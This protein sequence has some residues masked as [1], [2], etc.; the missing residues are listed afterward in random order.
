MNEQIY[1]PHLYLF[2]Y[3]LRNG[4]GQNSSQLAEN[5]HRFWERLPDELKVDQSA[6]EE[7]GYTEDIVDLLKLHPD[8]KIKSKRSYKLAKE[9]FEYIY[10]PVR[11]NDTYGLLFASSLN[12]DSTT[13]PIDISI[14]G[15]MRN[16]LR[17]EEASKFSGSY[18]VGKTW[19]LAGYLPPDF[20]KLEEDS[21]KKEELAEKAEAIASEAYEK[22]TGNKW[23]YPQ[24]GKF[25][26][27]W[28]FEVWQPPHT[29]ENLDKNSHVLIIIYKNLNGLEESA[30]FYEHWLPLFC[31]RNKVLW[32]YS[33]SKSKN[34]KI[35]KS[36]KDSDQESFYPSLPKELE[37]LKEALRDNYPILQ[38][39]ANRISFLEIQLH[40]IEVNRKNYKK[41]LDNIIQKTKECGDN[42]T[43]LS[44][45]EKFLDVAEQKY[46][47]QIKNDCAVIE[48][49]LRVREKFIDTIKGIVEIEQATLDTKQATL[50]KNTANRDRDFQQTIQVW[51]VGLATAGVAATA[52]SP[53]MEKIIQPLAESLQ[54]KSKEKQTSLQQTSVQSSQ[55]N[56]V[57]NQCP[58]LPTSIWWVPGVSLLLTVLVSFGIGLF[59]ANL[60]KMRVRSS[61]GEN[62]AKAVAG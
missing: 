19:M 25:L 17:T 56:P 22:F 15:E 36:N 18:D 4:L 57:A 21:D 24:K 23:Q 51:G 34:E 16:S 33:N 13:K 12:E 14:F 38:S 47:E 53:F 42:S 59:F 8:A 50:D 35:A 5:H 30:K 32:A 62:E 48:S 28:I 26:D 46:Q 58:P 41:R 3:N 6:E 11:L 39:Y 2:V 54:P 9:K 31:Y 1:Y 55:L 61:G 49:G 40:T 52:F 60:A 43:D 29:W 44:F 37:Q 7:V 20:P 27:G 10:Y 45:L